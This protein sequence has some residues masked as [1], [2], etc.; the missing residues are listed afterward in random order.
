MPE[1]YIVKQGDCISSIAFNA[2]FFPETL[3]DHPNNRQLKESRKN[4]NVLQEGD[5]VFIPDKRTKEESRTTNEVYKFRLKNTPAQLR[6]QLMEFKKPLAGLPFS[7]K[8]GGKVVSE[9][10]DR[11]DSQGFVTCKIPPD[12]R[13]GTLI[14]VDGSKTFEYDLQLGQLD[15]INTVSGLKQR[16]HN[17][18]YYDGPI[19]DLADE[20]L[21]N[22]IAE[23]QEDLGLE[24]TG[25]LDEQ[26]KQQLRS[27][28]DLA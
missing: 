2:G 14:V 20:E 19:N 22:A 23:Y 13:D 27:K 16:L 18:G 9:P 25:S 7:L 3:W 28:H 8:V 11:T 12:A 5:T 26:A 10:G 24:P 4:G 15:P 21:A 6:I 1:N 17:L